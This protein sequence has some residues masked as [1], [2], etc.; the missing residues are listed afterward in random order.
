MQK[1]ANSHKPWTRG[2]VV[3]MHKLIK[4]NTPTP[5]MAWKLKRTTPGVQSKA[6]DLG[7]STKPTNKSPYNRRKS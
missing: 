6:N 5:L 4:Q 2:Q 7:W 1:R 3:A